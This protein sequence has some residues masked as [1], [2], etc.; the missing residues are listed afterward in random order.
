MRR[1]ILICILI[2]YVLW[3]AV[4]ALVSTIQIVGSI[5]VL[6]RYSMAVL[7]P[8]T[9][10]Q[11]AYGMAVTCLPLIPT[12]LLQDVALGLQGMLP[13][14]LAWPNALQTS[15]GC[16]QAALDMRMN[17]SAPR[18]TLR[19]IQ[20]RCLKSCSSNAYHCIRGLIR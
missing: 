13:M 4:A 8:V 5:G 14:N 20:M 7:V 11:L 18:F 12:C 10:I 19:Q 9:G 2:A 6:I 3:A 15:P 1:N 17:A 16:I